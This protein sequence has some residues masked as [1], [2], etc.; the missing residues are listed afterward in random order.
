MA[1]P[2][3]TVGAAH[4]NPDILFM[5]WGDDR[6][7]RNLPQHDDLR[8]SIVATFDLPK[9]DKYVYH[10]NTSVTLTQVQEA[11]NHGREAG[12]HAWYRDE[13]GNPVLMPN[14]TS[15]VTDVLTV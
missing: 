4:F 5:T 12:L 11:I 15:I 7:K 9:S 8:A 10:A 2:Q 1:P 14:T 13:E 3:R 6:E